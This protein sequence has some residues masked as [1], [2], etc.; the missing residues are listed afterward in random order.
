M[1]YPGM[2]HRD[3]LASLRRLMAENGVDVLLITKYDPH[4]SEYAVPYWNAVRFVTG[5][6][7]SNATAVVTE[8]AAGLWTDG[9]YFIQAA[10][11]LAAARS[12]GV[13]AA[14]GI[15]DGAGSLP[16][17]AGDLPVSAG[18]GFVLHKSGEPGVRTYAE[19]IRD[20]APPGGMVGFDG[21][22]VSAAEAEKL[23]KSL[24]SKRVSLKTDIDIVG[25]IWEKRP[26]PPVSAVFDHDVRFCGLS[27][28]EKLARLREKIREADG[29]IYILSSL[30]DIAW[31]FNLRCADNESMT[32]PAYAVLAR[33]EAA[34]FTDCRLAGNDA[35]AA[36]PETLAAALAR[37]EAVLFTDCRL[38]GDDAA[39][40]APETLAAVL[41]RDNVG[42]RPYGGIGG[43]CAGI[44]SGSSVLLA[45]ERTAFALKNAL[46]NA[47]VTE[48]D[49]DITSKM[50][51]AK[52][53]AELAGVERAN[54]RDGAALCRFAVWLEGALAKGEIVT[55]GSAA[56]KLEE[57]RAAGENYIRPSFGTIAAYM[58]N[59]AMMHYSPADGGAAL[60][61][62]GFLLVDSGGQYRDGTTDI[63]RTFRLGPLSEKMRTDFTFVL[64]AHIALARAVFLSGTAGAHLD[65]LARKTMWDHG[66]DYRSGTGHGIGFCLSVHEGPPS[67]SPR[68]GSAS[69]CPLAPG[70]I[71]TDEPGIYRENEYGIRTENTLVVE[72][73]H[74]TEFGKFLRFRVTSWFPVDLAAIAPETLNGE[75]IEWLD[76]YHGEV[77][78]RL[79]PLVGEKEREWLRRATRKVSGL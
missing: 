50:K 39:T 1:S 30:D 36:A 49:A 21:R 15:P 46:R 63:T 17:G 9:R 12:E 6:T 27:R 2:S 29:D 69:A 56:E 48:L 52:N 14:D 25:V 73:S 31:L 40:A 10:R 4:Q 16:E 76:R 8:S 28:S 43:F 26:Q 42:V 35:A 60:R 64:K 5:F 57:F 71:V 23:M 55:E 54:L 67:V 44:K 53:G 75:E 32:F 7:G 78:E 58:E 24:A 19:F 45:P 33:D 13:S 59:A 66:L 65:V 62:E 70:M 34:L 51:A 77:Y 79:A 37:D 11:E 72:E 18:D 38:A 3:I 47:I 22:S 74:G 41:A 20:A 68:L 61:P